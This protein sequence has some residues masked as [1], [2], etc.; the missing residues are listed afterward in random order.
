MEITLSGWVVVLLA[1]AGMGATVA[2]LAALPRVV[3]APHF[4]DQIERLRGEIFDARRA[5]ILERT[6]E[7]ARLLERCDT[8]V[9]AVNNRWLE[10]L[11]ALVVESAEGP[12]GVYEERLA[13]LTKRAYIWG[14]WRNGVLYLIFPEAYKIPIG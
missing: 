13:A 9:T 7:V 2:L 3:F 12:L 11:G 14:R 1:L 4:A 10:G 8:V 6:S 5:G